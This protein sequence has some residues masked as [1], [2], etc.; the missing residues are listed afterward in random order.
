MQHPHLAVTTTLILCDDQHSLPCS[1][2]LPSHYVGC[3]RPQQYT[4]PS[5]TAASWIQA[6][7]CTPPY[8][9]PPSHPPWSA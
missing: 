9:S 5:I 3:H 6:M 4:Q 7:Y 8:P 1:P 2:S